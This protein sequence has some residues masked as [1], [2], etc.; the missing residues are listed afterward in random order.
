M[1]GTMTE[2]QSTE[3][4][5]ALSVDQIAAALQDPKIQESPQ[6]SRA[7]GLKSFKNSGFSRNF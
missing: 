5:P 1:E 7:R 2:Q 3:R 4:L 6:A